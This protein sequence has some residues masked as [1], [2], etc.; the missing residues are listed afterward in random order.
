MNKAAWVL[1]TLWLWSLSLAALATPLQIGPDI[2]YTV[3]QDP[4]GSYNL[5]SAR[6]RLLAPASVPQRQVFAR[7][8]TTAA[9]WLRSVLPRSAFHGSA[10]WMEIKPSFVDDVQLFYRPLGSDGPWQHRTTGDNA[11]MPRSDLDYRF[12]VFVIPA[13]PADASGYEII[14]R[15]ANRG[16]LLLRPTLWQPAAFVSDAARSSAWQ[17]FYFGLA[18]FSTLAAVTLGLVFKSRLFWSVAALAGPYLLLACL[19]GYAAWLVPQAGRWLQDMLTAALTLL[20]YP[21]LL[22]APVEALDIRHR[23]P[24]LYRLFGITCGLFALLLIFSIGTDFYPNAIRIQTVVFAATSLAL[25][26]AAIHILRNERPDLSTVLLSLGPFA[27]LAVSFLGMLSLREIVPYRLTLY[28]VWQYV[29]MANMLLV[30]VVALIQVRKQ[31]QQALASQRLE[32][33]LRIERE[34]RFRQ[35]QFLGM[36]AHEF[37]TPMAVISACLANLNAQTD[38]RAALRKRH[39]RIA[40]ATDRLV[41]LTDTCLADARLAADRLLVDRRDVSLTAL[42]TS[43]ASLVDVSD[44]HSWRLSFAGIDIDDDAPV[45]DRAFVDDALLRIAISNVVDNAVKYTAGGRIQGDVSRANGH[46]RIAIA[47]A[48]HGIAAQAVATLFERFSRMPQPEHTVR[49]FG[50]GLHV[51]RQIARAHGGELALERN[52]PQ[53]CLFVFTLPIVDSSRAHDALG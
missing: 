19:E 6:Q 21:C 52:T 47:D 15:V 2:A 51:S 1:A 4:Q 28:T 20:L 14:F 30:M 42:M 11:R 7:D 31:R 32:A 46:W 34:A 9:Y 5:D 44:R 29:L 36:V 35:R 24:R 40:R 13:L 10:L 8:Y 3:V 25:F 18:F 48:G 26:W 43:A 12:P 41:Q 53:G 38:D 37:R 50:L 45:N 23:R 39:E 27:M 17:A 49:G 16:P 33:D 22:W